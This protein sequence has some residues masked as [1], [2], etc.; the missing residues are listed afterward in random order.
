MGREPT[1]N[2]YLA[3]HSINVP[4]GHE[5]SANYEGS[6]ATLRG[7]DTIPYVNFAA[8]TVPEPV[9]GNP[10]LQSVALQNT[11]P[12]T[13]QGIFPDWLDP[14]GI[15]NKAA[16][17]A[18]A[19]VEDYVNNTLGLTKEDRD[20]IYNLPMTVGFILLAIVLIGIGVWSLVK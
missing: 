7:A 9:I 13:P 20:W 10:A 4:W 12:N 6:S 14:F 1:G 8:S 15:G 17:A 16:D 5:A 18:G 19:T 11:G 3:M 2:Y